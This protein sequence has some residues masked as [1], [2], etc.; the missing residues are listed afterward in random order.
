MRSKGIP[1]LGSGLVFPLNEDDLKV[2]P[3]PLPEYWPRLCGIDFG[4]DHP[5][6]AVWIAWD[7]DTDTVYVY[8]CYRKSSETPVVHSAAIRERGDWVPVVWP[9][10]GSQHDKGSGHSLADIYRKQ[11]LNMMHTH[12][13]NPKGDISIEPGIMEM[14]QRMETGRFKVFSYLRDWYEE[15]RMY[16][17]SYTHLTLPTIYSV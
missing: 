12:F 3:F 4:W 10:D 13:T 6:A 8:D 11:G 17:V 7:R 2:E 15:V 5:T 16:P 1:V 14:L 9:H